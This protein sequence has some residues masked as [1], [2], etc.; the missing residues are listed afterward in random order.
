M[1]LSVINNVASLN[2]QSNLNRTSTSLAQSLERLSSGLK[3]NRGADGPAAL[4]ISEEQR[5]QIAGLT[6]AIDNTNKAVSLVQTAEGALNEINSLLVQIRGLALDSANSGVNDATSLAANQAQ[7][8]NALS[9]IDSIA[10]N[11]QF[12]TKRLLNGAAQQGALA[13]TATGVTV[14]GTLTNPAPA[15]HYTYS[16]TTAA[17]EAV[18]TG[19]AG[20]AGTGGTVGTGN[21][22]TFTINGKTVTLADTDTVDTAVTKINNVLSSNNVNIKASDV[23]GQLKLTATDFTTDITVAAGTLTLANIGLNNTAANHTNGVLSY[24]DSTGATINVTGAGNVFNL[25]GELA[26][27]TVTLAPDATTPTNSV[28]PTNQTFDVG[29]QLV[30]QIG[31]NAN[32]TASISIASVRTQSLGVGVVAGVTSLHSIDV[33]TSTGAQNAISVIDSAISQVSSQRGTLGAFQANTLQETANNLST[34]LQNT[35]A[36]ESVIRDT[37]Y[38]AEISR[39]TKEQVQLQAGASVLTSANQVPAIINQLLKG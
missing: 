16:V 23:G 14:T 12:G 24:I 2:A 11:T 27:T 5:A 39:F 32:Q 30:F 33:T 7:I 15:L 31:A 1:G 34:I 20:F 6:T 25:T 38:A 36:A 4:V 8:A 28:T 37:D 35:T 26:G 21:G 18:K 9:T 3:I 13:A 29:Q 19:A 10:N 17:Q 22:G